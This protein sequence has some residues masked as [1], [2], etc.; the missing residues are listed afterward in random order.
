MGCVVAANAQRRSW[1]MAEWTN[2]E[3]IQLQALWAE[4]HSTAEIGRRLGR[5]KNS[6]VGHSHRLD[7]PPRPSP[8]IRNGERK[9]YPARRVGPVRTLPLLTSEIDATEVRRQGDWITP[10]RDEV[11]KR[12]WPMYKPRI[13]IL[14][15]MADLPGPLWPSADA[16]SDH[17]RCTLKL[18][19][20]ADLRA[21][22][23]PPPAPRPA[24]V[25]R[26]EPVPQVYAPVRG[27][28]WPLGD[29]GMPDFRFCDAPHRNKTY[30][31]L[32][33][34]MAY[35]RPAR[36]HDAIMTIDPTDKHAADERSNV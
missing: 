21:V 23:S 24:P 6:V 35:V 9:P 36:R 19:R 34:A 2:D 29:V 31:T 4:G 33:A 3:D 32:H 17:A 28:L 11:L 12:W 22:V 13:E 1:V 25:V 5:T 20:P 26:R 14:R 18:K 8:I 30:C 15:I 7:L 16:V 10:E 27:C